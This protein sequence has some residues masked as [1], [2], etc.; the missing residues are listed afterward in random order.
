MFVLTPELCSL[1]RGYLI[2]YFCSAPVRGLRADVGECP[3]G[4]EQQDPCCPGQCSGSVGASSS[5]QGHHEHAPRDLAPCEVPGEQQRAG[6]PP[7]TLHST[8]LQCSHGR[9]SP[10]DLKELI[11][12]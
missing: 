6:E 12:L 4:R 3:E 7:S 8:G 9:S 11:K 2:L 10:Q 5:H 1:R